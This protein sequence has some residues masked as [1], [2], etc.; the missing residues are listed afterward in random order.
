[1]R[2]EQLACGGLFGLTVLAVLAWWALIPVVDM[3]ITPVDPAHADRRC[4]TTR[5]ALLDAF[6]S[7]ERIT[8]RLC[9]SVA[10]VRT[11]EPALVS[12]MWYRSAV[13]YAT[14]RATLECEA[15]SHVFNATGDGV[16][17]AT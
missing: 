9:A 13:H 4:W 10:A 3:E 17:V 8:V 12:A 7:E 1:M 14:R 2:W 5:Y 6:R 11:N 16:G 15:L